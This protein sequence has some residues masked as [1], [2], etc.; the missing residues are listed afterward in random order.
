M[1]TV[2][3]LTC[4]AMDPMASRP[5]LA[6]LCCTHQHLSAA[7]AMLLPAIPVTHLACSFARN[8]KQELLHTGGTDR[9]SPIQRCPFRAANP[10][11]WP[12]FVCSCYEQER[13][14][15]A[16]YEFSIRKWVAAAYRSEDPCFAI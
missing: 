9:I 1:A 13:T 10:D 11:W 12:V 15:F 4:R 6:C 14:K 7:G 8:G 3:G 2:A 5:L 16:G